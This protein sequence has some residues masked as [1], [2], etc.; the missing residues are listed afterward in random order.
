MSNIL[1]TMLAGLQDPL[2]LLIVVFGGGM[3]AITIRPAMRAM[4]MGPIRCK[5]CQH[6]GKVKMTMMGKLVCE[7]CGSADWE[8][9]PASS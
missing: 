1:Q 5:R 9:A 7:Q 2:V 4:K 6:V 3:A 8:N